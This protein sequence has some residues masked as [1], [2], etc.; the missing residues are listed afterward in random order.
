LR[1][2]FRAGDVVLFADWTLLRLFP[3]LRA[4]WAPIGAQATVPISGANAKRVLFGA[5]DLRTARR[6]VLVRRAAGQ[7]DA[8]AFLRELRRRYRR[9]GTL[10]LLLDRASAHTAPGTQRLAAALGLVLLWLPKQH[11]ALNPMDQLW[12]ELKRLVAANR[13]AGS[14]DALADEATAWVLGLTPAEA[15]RKS[16]MA[17]DRFWL[18]RLRHDFWQPT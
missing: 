15:R 13:Q 9:A 5:I 8:Q 6:A 1:R 16:G 10:W 4:T 7:A 11:P 18:K 12:R 17:S 2:G 3:P 14:V